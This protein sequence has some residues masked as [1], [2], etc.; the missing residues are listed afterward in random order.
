MSLETEFH[1]RN[2]DGDTIHA[3]FSSPQELKQLEITSKEHGVLDLKNTRYRFSRAPDHKEDT[4]I[5]LLFRDLQLLLDQESDPS[6]CLSFKLF[7][8]TKEKE[9][10]KNPGEKKS[11]KVT[12]IKFGYQPG[13]QTM[14]KMS[15]VGFGILGGV[16]IF[17]T[18]AGMIAGSGLLAAGAA[19]SALMGMAVTAS[20]HAFVSEIDYDHK[21]CSDETRHAGL[22]GFLTGAVTGFLGPMIGSLPR[23]GQFA[24]AVASKVP[25]KATTVVKVIVAGGLGGASGAFDAIEDWHKDKGFKLNKVFTK[26][27]SSTAGA[28]A[29]NTLLRGSKALDALSGHVRTS[30]A[31]IV[32]KVVYGGV[33]AGVRQATGNVLEGKPVGDLG[34]AI[35]LEGGM[36]LIGAAGKKMGKLKTT[37]PKGQLPTSPQGPNLEEQASI[38]LIDHIRKHGGEWADAEGRFRKFEP[39]HEPEMRKIIEDSGKLRFKTHHKQKHEELFTSPNLQERPITQDLPQ[40]QPMTGPSTAHYLL[41]KLVAETKNHFKDILDR[42][43]M[44][45]SKWVDVDGLKYECSDQYREAIALRIASGKNVVIEGQDGTRTVLNDRNTYYRNEAYDSWHKRGFLGIS[46][47]QIARS[48]LPEIKPVIDQQPNGNPYGWTWQQR[49]AYKEQSGLSGIIHTLRKNGGEWADEKGK[50][51][52]FE[53]HHEPELRRVAENTGRLRYKEFPNQRRVVWRHTDTFSRRSKYEGYEDLYTSP[54]PELLNKPLPTDL[55]KQQPVAHPAPQP[56]I[57]PTLKPVAQPKAPDIGLPPFITAEQKPKDKTDISPRQYQQEKA[58]LLQNLEKQKQNIKNQMSEIAGFVER[59]VLE[60]R[61]C[62]SDIMKMKMKAD[63]EKAENEYQKLFQRM[64]NVSKN[65]DIVS[66]Q[67]LHNQ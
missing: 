28:V 15:S 29:S 22:S 20:Q 25:V 9:S 30:T 14:A 54:N 16:G 50:F 19:T 33:G 2:L 47:V 34:P 59:K 12:F 58:R 21:Q 13:G 49:E 42:F 61:R 41:N 1:F 56:V 55:P 66:G 37:P 38:E 10:K 7:A 62:R 51:H 11:V 48:D 64:L 32:D 46:A 63:K 35:L 27:L 45:G 52:K 23:V 60:M 53:E 8:E 4:T 26:A 3:I 17:I 36:A 18:G 39:K 24:N 65:I 67:T 43:E 57:L 44:S 40:P 31:Q 6:N 5:Q